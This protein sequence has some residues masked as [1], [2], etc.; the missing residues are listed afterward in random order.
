MPDVSR[1]VAGD[2]T[3]T[4][5][6]SDD[7]RTQRGHVLA[8]CKPDD[9]VLVHDADGY[10]PAA[11]L[12][13]PAELTVNEDPLWLVAVDGDESLHVEAEGE[14]TV[15][16]YDASAAG[17]P[18]GGCRCGGHL[19]RASGGVDCLA[20]DAE[21]PL[22]GG[23]TVLQDTC[24]DCGLPRI[25]VDRG[26]TVELCLDYDCE[27]LLSAVEARFDREWDC[28]ECGGALEILRRGG[29]VAG[30]E[31]YPE[32]ETGFAIPDGTI[33]GDCDCGLPVFE[34]ASGRR[35]LDSTCGV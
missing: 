15:T 9:T 34:T 3:V 1:I 35:C 2:C 12:T 16:R 26:E 7:T 20:C 8:L 4:Y 17:V 19:V 13:R 10:Q 22:P 27:S 18:V 29:L 21:Y 6:S 28:P 33:V 24:K 5:T 11:W 30:C 14:V 31:H 25:R 23:A 32:C